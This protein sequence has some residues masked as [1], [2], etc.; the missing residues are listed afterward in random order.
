[1]SADMEN[2]SEPVQL[3]DGE[4]TDV[5][6]NGEVEVIPESETAED[7]PVRKAKRQLSRQRSGSD[8][9]NN[10][11]AVKKALPNSKNSRKSR[12]GRG[13]GL[14]KKGGAGGKGV[15]GRPGEELGEDGN[16][17]DSHDPNYDSDS[18]DSN[19]Q[20]EK[21]CPEMSQEDFCKFINPVVME[22]YEHG[23]TKDVLEELNDINFEHLK[24]TLVECLISKALDHKDHHRELTSVLISD[25]Y[26]R[27]LSSDD[28]V[29]GFDDVLGKLSDLTI[30]TPDAATVVGKF[31]A[32]AV[33]DDCLPPKYIM[34]YRGEETEEDCPHT[35]LAV[36]HADVLLNQTHGIV[37]LDNIWGQGG[38]TRPVKLL[39][40]KIVM[41]LKEY[42][43]SGD[44]TE[45]T[46]C[47]T[48]L[49]VPHF[50][51]EVIYEAIVMVL[52]ESSQRAAEMMSKFLKSLAE[53]V[54]ITPQQI[55]Q[56]FARAYDNMPDICLDVPNAYSLLEQFCT[57]CNKEG[58]LS[59]ALMKDLPQRGRKRFVSE[60][61]GGRIKSS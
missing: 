26:G 14:P 8:S 61:D 13:R 12:D 6:M 47:L 40:R 3:Q 16:T 17:V 56:G 32:R 28:V 20:F 15:W 23:N 52:E 45:A 25:L 53:A 22:F 42:L 48:E 60:G 30:D 19:I 18:Q 2:V 50:H 38:G 31:I 5:A 55:G 33:A 36:D 34:K 27:V 7:R 58:F 4:S 57:L 39:I 37:R 43:S 41:L 9:S 24:R 46:H 21:I 1:M 10:N 35:K 44:I 51:H 59:D 11:A 54:I 49:D 29:D